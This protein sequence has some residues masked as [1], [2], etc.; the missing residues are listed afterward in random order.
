MRA[1]GSRSC[2]APALEPYGPTRAGPAFARRFI[3][4]ETLEH[5]I[6]RVDACWRIGRRTAARGAGGLDL[7][8]CL[9]LGLVPGRTP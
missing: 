3:G 1:S 6:E 7:S 8:R 5:G 2:A 9:A 4:G